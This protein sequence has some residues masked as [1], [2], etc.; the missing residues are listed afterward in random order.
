MNRLVMK[1]IFFSS[2]SLLFLLFLLLLEACA[3]SET[4]SLPAPD[5]GEGSGVYVSISVAVADSQGTQS[6]AIGSPKPG[7]NGDDLQVGTGDEN[8]VHDLN[9]FFF[10]TTDGKGINT[11]DNAAD[12]ELVSVFFDNLTPEPSGN[13]TRYLTPPTE[14]DALRVGETYEILVVA[15]AGNKTISNITN[16]ADLRDACVTQAIEDTDGLCFLMASAG[17][18]IDKIEIL[19]GNSQ[20]NP[21]IVTVNVE[22]LAAR[23]D[24]LINSSYEPVQS[25]DDKVVITEATLVNKHETSPY[26][27]KRVSENVQNLEPVIYLGDEKVADDGIASNYVLDAQTIA[28][29]NRIY[30]LQFDGIMNVT[31]SPWLSITADG[32]YHTLDY[33]EENVVIVQYVEESMSKYCTGVVFKARYTPDGMKEGTSF[34]SY[35]GKIYEKLSD[36]ETAMGGNIHLDG[37][38]Y[39]TYGVS[40]YKDG[41]CYYTYWIRHADDGNPNVI[42]PMEYAI[43]RNNLYQLKV[44]SIS[45]IGGDK[46][47]TVSDINIR[48]NVCDWEETIE[49]SIT[50]D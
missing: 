33:T 14:V 35:A 23:V 24:Y 27:F 6:R 18:G 3:D 29:N 9:V 45:G 39:S 20:N 22:R 8:E 13:I 16:L 5:E 21:S 30:L 25:P 42:S 15:N 50:W 37:N 26:V 32:K 4:L 36:V 41:I 38:N 34:Y 43:V 49:G 46:P 31:H 7:E 47:E 11:S 1:H 10:Q 40:Y 48:V 2:I 17:S 19:A 28:M 12:I 44:N